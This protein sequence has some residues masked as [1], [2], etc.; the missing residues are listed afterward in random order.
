MKNHA[1]SQGLSPVSL[2]D[3]AASHLCVTVVDLVKLLKIRKA[4]PAELEQEQRDTLE[5]R[6]QEPS[7]RVS[8]VP[9]ANGRTVPPPLRIDA[10]RKDQGPNGQPLS[11]T[12]SD[13]LSPISPFL[14]APIANG[15][16]RSN[17]PV[18]SYFPKPQTEDAKRQPAPVQTSSS[19]RYNDSYSATDQRNRAIKPSSSVQP[20]AYN[21]SVSE[22][23]NSP[24]RELPDE[25]AYQDQIDGDGDFAE[26]RVSGLFLLCR[27]H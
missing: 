25:V 17:S 4:H 22:V 26:F 1:S 3:A 11:A 2:L 15:S 19:H 24:T 16:S 27:S 7:G 10:L 12:E 21:R 5:D 23:S 20:N 9:R 8:P 6:L 14:P 18:T 13:R